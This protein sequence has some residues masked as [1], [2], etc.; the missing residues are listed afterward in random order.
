MEV[1]ARRPVETS[2]EN[3]ERWVTVPGTVETWQEQSVGSCHGGKG[4]FVEELMMSTTAKVV[5]SGT[6]SAGGTRDT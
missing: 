1:R 3:G 2:R 6:V 4:Q 5:G